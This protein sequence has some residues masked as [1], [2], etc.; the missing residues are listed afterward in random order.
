MALQVR[1]KLRR[2]K[3]EKVQVARQKFD[4]GLEDQQVYSFGTKV[5]HRPGQWMA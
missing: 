2:L 5:Q 1:A 3:V 4:V